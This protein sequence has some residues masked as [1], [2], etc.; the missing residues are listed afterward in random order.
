MNSG[1][2]NGDT[3]DP[4]S[5]PA[6]PQATCSWT[7]CFLLLTELQSTNT[8]K[9]FLNLCV[10]DG[11]ETSSHPELWRGH[12]QGAQGR[13]SEEESLLKLRPG[14]I[15]LQLQWPLWRCFWEPPDT[16]RDAAEK[17]ES[18]TVSRRNARA[19]DKVRSNDYRVTGTQQGTSARK[20]V[21][22]VFID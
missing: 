21:L 14:W 5:T 7:S 16:T 22:S 1:S 15:R 6:S 12:P 17:R 8:T 2:G 3:V 19:E 13:G 11:N 10:C 9:S 4:S 18:P 20:E